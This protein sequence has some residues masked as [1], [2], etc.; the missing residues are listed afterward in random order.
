MSD[1]TGRNTNRYTHDQVLT[2]NYHYRMYVFE[3]RLLVLTRKVR[4][5][6]HV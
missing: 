4:K 6:S 3:M 5:V 2:E 1:I